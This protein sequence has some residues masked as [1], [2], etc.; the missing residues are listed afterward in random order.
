MIG[1]KEGVHKLLVD[2]DEKCLT[3]VSNLNDEADSVLELYPQSNQLF[4]SGSV[5]NDIVLSPT[6]ATPQL[7]LKTAIE[8]IE[9]PTLA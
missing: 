3:Y 6:R 9:N 7:E 5:W 2:P 4:E 1:W 8:K